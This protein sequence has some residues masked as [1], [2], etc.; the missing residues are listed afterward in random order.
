MGDEIPWVNI[1]V[2]VVTFNEDAPPI[3]PAGGEENGK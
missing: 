3:I 1:P 2:G